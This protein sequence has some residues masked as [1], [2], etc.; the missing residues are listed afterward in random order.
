VKEKWKELLRHPLIW[1][2]ALFIFGFTLWDLLLPAREF[3]ETEN[4]MLQQKPSFTIKSLMASGEQAY[5]RKYEKYINDQ[6]VLRDGW[7]SLK[8]RVESILAKI[9]NNNVAYGKDG[10]LF[11]KVFSIDEKNLAA[12]LRYIGEF[13]DKYP[14]LPV[15]FGVIPNAYSVLT[16]KVPIG[17]SA[18]SVEQNQRIEELYT[19]LRMDYPSLKLLSL[20][21]SL[22]AHKNE[23]IYYHTDHHWTTYG[24]YLGY[25]EYVRSLGMEPVDLTEMDAHKVEGFYG[26]FDAKA[27][28][29]GTLSDTIVWYDIPCKVEINQEPVETLHDLSRFEVR[30][31]YSGLMHGNKALTVLFSECNQNPKEGETSRVLVVKD[32]YGNSFAPYLCYHFDEVYVVDLRYLGK[33]SAVLVDMDLN[34]N[35]VLILYN[36]MNFVTD[37]NIPKLR[38]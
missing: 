11:E 5:S 18:V 13:L 12:N 33:M 1:L 10:Y 14:N 28:K 26:T 2:F 27:K 22:S 7:I 16:D 31:K 29:A 9:E 35:D 24:A 37:T 15:T 3:S 20:S 23:D 21:E 30:D 36:F 19:H 25:A 38:Y 6:F 17:F 34:F 32:S 8:S 4:R